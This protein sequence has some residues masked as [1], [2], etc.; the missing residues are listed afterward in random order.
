MLLVR[1][2]AASS[3]STVQLYW[4]GTVLTHQRATDLIPQASETGIDRIFMAWAAGGEA[5]ARSGRNAR[6]ATAAPGLHWQTMDSA[7]VDRV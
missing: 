5:P 6:V 7:T 1:G 2:I 3:S 4:Y